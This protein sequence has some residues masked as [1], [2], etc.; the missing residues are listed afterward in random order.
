MYSVII[1]KYMLLDEPF[2]FLTIRWLGIGYKY[3]KK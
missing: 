2:D 3:S 1:I